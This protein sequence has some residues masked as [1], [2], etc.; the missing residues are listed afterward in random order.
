MPDTIFE[1]L[2]KELPGIKKDVLLKD[3]TTFRLGGPADYF[4]IAKTKE[5]VLR[6][7][8][9]AKKLKLSLF[10]FGGGSNLLVSDSGIRG[11]VVRMQSNEKTFFMGRENTISAYAGISLGSLVDFSVQ[12]GLAGLEWAG[13][14]PGT[15]LATFD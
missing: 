1:I 9:T 12:K 5:D 10:I 8:K 3:H 14:L 6:A 15:V 2:K 13:G 11:L 4:F 7:I